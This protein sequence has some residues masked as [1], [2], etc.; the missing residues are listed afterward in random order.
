LLKEELNDIKIAKN[1]ENK[2]LIKKIDELVITIN[3][4]EQVVSDL[5]N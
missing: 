3:K 5:E 1:K 2:D 4:Y